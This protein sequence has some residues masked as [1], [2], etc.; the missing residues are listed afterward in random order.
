MNAD[1]TVL[2]DGMRARIKDT[3]PGRKSDPGGTAADS[4]PFVEAV[5]WRF[6]TG[7][8]WR[9]I[10]ERFGGND[11]VSRRFRRRVLSGVSGRVSDTLSGESGLE[12]VSGG[13]T[14]VQAHRKAAGSKGG[15]RPGHRT[16]P[17]RPDDQG[18][19]RGGRARL[20]GPLHGPSRTGARPE[21]VPDLPGGLPF[22]TLVGD[23]ASGADWLLEH[24]ERRGGGDSVEAEPDGAA[25][26]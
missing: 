25:G 6:R 24:L 2:T 14:V 19:G 9:G 8:P 20:P 5:L 21:G 13:G 4:R 23:G 11:S 22:G 16:L 17:G 12:G 1:G 18:R 26:A 7:S 3:L 15:P 10:P